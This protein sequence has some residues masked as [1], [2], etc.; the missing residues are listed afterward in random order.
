MHRSIPNVLKIS[1]A[2]LAGIKTVASHIA[3]DREE[4]HTGRQSRIF[5]GILAIS[6]QIQNLFPL[7]GRKF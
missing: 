4:R 1:D 6:D 2:N 5:L 7:F 3:N